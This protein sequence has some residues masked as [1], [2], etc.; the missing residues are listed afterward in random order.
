LCNAPD[1]SVHEAE[2]FAEYFFPMLW[3]KHDVVPA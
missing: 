2:W 3:W 1:P